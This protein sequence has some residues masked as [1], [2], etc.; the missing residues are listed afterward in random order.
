MPMYMFQGAYTPEAWAEQIK[1][2]TNRLAIVAKMT[3]ESGGKVVA[4]YYA[5][6]PHDFIIIAEMPDNTTAAAWSIAAAAGGALSHFRTVPLMTEEEG[7]AA[8]RAAG[9]STYR[10]PR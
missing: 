7:L 4:Q 3:E 5:F 9:K 8:V 2:P 1:N 10:R 6:G